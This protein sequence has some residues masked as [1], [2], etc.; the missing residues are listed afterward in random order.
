MFSHFTNTTLKAIRGKFSPEQFSTKLMMQSKEIAKPENYLIWF[1]ERFHYLQSIFT[2]YGHLK[3]GAFR[4]T[5]ADIIDAWLNKQDSKSSLRIPISEYLKTNN[6]ADTKT[7]ANIW[8]FSIPYQLY[9]IIEHGSSNY[10]LCKIISHLNNENICPVI[11][12]F[13]EDYRLRAIDIFESYAKFEEAIMAELI[14]KKPLN[15]SIDVSKLKPEYFSALCYFISELGADRIKE[16]PIVCEL[17]LATP[18]IPSMSSLK[19]FRDNS[20]NWRFIK[21]IDVL[22]NA[23]SLP[24]IDF[25]NDSTFYSYSNTV[26]NLCGYETFDT[27]W[28]SAEKYASQTEL[29]MAKEMRDAIK[30]K[31]EHPWMLSY[32]MCNTQF[33]SEEYNRFMPYYNIVDDCIYYNTK[34][35]L[36]SELAFENHFQ[37]LA[38]QICGNASPHCVDVTKLMCGD[39]YMGT[40]I[41]PHYIR[42][43]CNGYIDKNS[44]LPELKLDENGDI[45]SGCTFEIVLNNFDTSIKDIEIGNI[46]STLSL[47]EISEHIKKIKLS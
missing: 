15:Q 5:T 22:K 20:P 13:D 39:S 32:P 21:I 31:K 34:Y 43:E 18:H 41:C 40:D 46:L 38:L 44:N 30:Y 7:A 6:S 45:T 28:K 47:T 10:D 12:L 29:S 2:P 9:G 19:N 35:I 11:R 25:N 1:H 26:L 16:F 4:S 27:A 33:V 3:W 17:A 37:A 8:F 14:L 23:S 36:P 24:N 42:G